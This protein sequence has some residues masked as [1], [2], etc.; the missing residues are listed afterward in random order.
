MVSG[1][2]K[3]LSAVCSLLGGGGGVGCV[4][5]NSRSLVGGCLPGACVASVSPA[6]ALSPPK[7]LDLV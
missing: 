6:L 5:P 1:P 4:S 7:M 2:P 3:S